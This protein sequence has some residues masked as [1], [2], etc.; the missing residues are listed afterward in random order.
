MSRSSINERPRR[1]R[2]SSVKGAL[3]LGLLAREDMSSFASLNSEPPDVKRHENS[4]FSPRRENERNLLALRISLILHRSQK[5]G[6][7]NIFL[8][9]RM[10]EDEMGS[11][12]SAVAS[13]WRIKSSSSSSAVPSRR[14]HVQ[15]EAVTADCETAEA[16]FMLVQRGKRDTHTHTGFSQNAH[17]TK[18]L[19]SQ[20]LELKDLQPLILY[21][22][23]IEV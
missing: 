15:T 6:R 18:V 11:L 13:W 21:N 20:R 1:E 16:A 17:L 12:F 3:F 4:F 9:F 5:P 22:L 19:A 8:T 23:F 2:C 14:L 7:E 10:R